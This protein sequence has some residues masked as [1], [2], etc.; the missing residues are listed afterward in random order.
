MAF[1][2]SAL[3]IALEKTEGI[4]GD[5]TAL[6]A[7]EAKDEGRK[8][9]SS[10]FLNPGMDLAGALKKIPGEKLGAVRE[11]F[12]SVILANLVLPRGEEDVKAVEPVAA[13]LEVLINDKG[14]IKTLK[15]QLAGF[16]QQWLD[17]KKQLEEALHQ[18]LGPMLKQ[19]EAQLTR[20]MG[21]AVRI[22]PRSDPDYMKA[23][24]ANMGN[25]E[26]QYAQA[27]NQAKEDI[28]A[29]LEK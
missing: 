29:L 12:V 16:F 18:Q 5:R 3:E 7:A 25:I 1:I 10:F 20:Q 4:K 28:A 24:N 26:N 27:L 19:K 8:L 14:R 6:T 13:A 17:D 15:A 22:D 11:G 9:A 23:Y 21:R 2:K